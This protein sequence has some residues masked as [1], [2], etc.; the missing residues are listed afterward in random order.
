MK[1]VSALLLLA[2]L[3]VAGSQS[4]KAQYGTGIGARLGPYL[5]LTL[6]HNFD[7]NSA[8]EGILEAR[9]RGVFI[10]GLY[11]YHIPIDAVDGLR[12]YVGGGAHIGYW[13]ESRGNTIYGPVGRGAFI[14]VDA[15]LGIE[16]TFDAAPINIS[17]D[18][19][20]AYNFSNNSNGAGYDNGA[21]SIRY[22][23]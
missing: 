1:K 19:K 21:L 14:G 11:E 4:L 17:L 2:F 10:T 6:K 13:T 7:S 23:F 5:G 18:Y 8:L 3:M 9:Y 12:V 20:P 15:I 22:V 16:Y